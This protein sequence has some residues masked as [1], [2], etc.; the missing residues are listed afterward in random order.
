MRCYRQDNDDV[1]AE[2]DTVRHSLQILSSNIR[3]FRQDNDDVQAASKR[4]L[5]FQ[6]R[7]AGVFQKD[8]IRLHDQGECPEGRPTGGR[9]TL[10][11]RSMPRR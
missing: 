7:F 1:Y 4:L 10:Y 8:F 3:C 5:Q 6:R 9:C 11:R 2:K